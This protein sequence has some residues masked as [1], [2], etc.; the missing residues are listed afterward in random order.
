MNA[1]LLFPG[2]DWGVDSVHRAAVRAQHRRG[3]DHVR[4]PAA[5]LAAARRRSSASRPTAPRTGS[6]RHGPGMTPQQRLHLLTTISYKQWLMDYLGAPEEAI[7]EY[8]RGSHGLLGAGAQVTSAIDN[9]M[10][11]R[12]GFSA[13]NLCSARPTAH[14][15]FPGMGRTPQMDNQTGQPARRGPG[16][17][18]TC[19]WPGCS[20]AGWCRRPSPTATGRTRRTSSRPAATTP[21]STS[22]RT[23]SGSGS[24]ASSTGQG[25][26]SS[27]GHGEGR[28]RGHRDGRGVIV[29]AKHV[30]MACW[31]RVTAQMVKGL[32]DQ[33]VEDLS[34]ARKVPLIY[35][36]ASLKNWRA[37]AD[38]GISSI[39]PRGKSM[40]WD[41]MSVSVGGRPFGAG[42]RTDAEQPPTS[43]RRS[44]S[45]SS[46]RARRDSAARRVRE[47]APAAARDELRGPRGL[48][49]RH[50]RPTVN[51]KG[52]DFDPERDLDDIM[53]NRWNYGYAHELSSLSTPR[54][55][56]RNE[57]PHRK[58][59]VPYENIAIAARTRRASP[60][61]TARS[62]R[63]SAR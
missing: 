22:R 58:G 44:S 62:T 14:A 4:E 16:P 32:P 19:R 41:S 36:R 50:A 38:A 52:G 35:A 46:P 45:R 21:S 8:Q 6:R 9:Y 1:H 2:E 63:A 13:A 23:T 42:L 54:S 12:P 31:N 15:G 37:F 43:R 51:A 55:T 30:V 56:A 10:L 47:R 24:T 57:Q 25:R 26:R 18:A 39:S 59:S 49:R 33:Q 40:F 53:I 17:T 11:G 48:A 60:T 29:R 5:V 20:S 7:A 61:R 28:V 3:L 34:Y 27:R